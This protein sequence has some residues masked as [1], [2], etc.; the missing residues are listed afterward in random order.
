MIF[1]LDNQ[2]RPRCSDSKTTDV[3]AGVLPPELYAAWALN[4]K[5]K[6]LMA[7]T[8]ALFDCAARVQARKRNAPRLIFIRTFSFSLQPTVIS[9]H[10]AVRTQPNTILTGIADGVRLPA[11]TY[12]V[13][14][15]SGD[16]FKPLYANDP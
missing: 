16:L 14:P 4:V 6:E 10:V 3:H 8:A 7:Y 9:Y 5:L 12:G 2:L 11:Q 13:D 1:S 15:S